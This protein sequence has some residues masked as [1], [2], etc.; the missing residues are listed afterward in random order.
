M[1][2]PGLGTENTAVNRTEQ[3]L[4]PFKAYRPHGGNHKS[5]DSQV[6]VCT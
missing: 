2:G 1:P 5:G 4:G 3:S 6:I